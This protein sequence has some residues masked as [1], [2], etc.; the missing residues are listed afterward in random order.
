MEGLDLCF[1]IVSRVGAG[2]AYSEAVS[3][4]FLYIYF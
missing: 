2:Y 3:R 1:E 4:N